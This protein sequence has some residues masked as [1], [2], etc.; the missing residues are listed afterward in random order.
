MRIGYPQLRSALDTPGVRVAL[1]LATCVVLALLCGH[2]LPPAHRRPFLLAAST[3]FVA[4]PL[5]SRCRSRRPCDLW[6]HAGLAG[7]WLGDYLG[8]LQFDLG[9][10]AFALAHLL[11][12]RGFLLRDR[13]RLRVSGVRTLP[14]V[15]GLALLVWLTPHLDGRDW[16]VVGVYLPVIT[17]MVVLALS[18]E[19]APGTAWLAWGAALFYVSDIFVARGRF[20][21][22]GEINSLLC[23]PLYYAA[24]TCFALGI[25]REPATAQTG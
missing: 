9:A 17:A 22:S 16:W 25:G 24:C 1:G 19:S 21:S 12:V 4:I 8:P 3:L 7:C 11:F 20:V 2:G 18:L 13:R 15:A 6:I 5:F 23:Y 10:L 14:F